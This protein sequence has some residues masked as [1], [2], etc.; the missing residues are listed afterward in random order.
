MI[1]P[2]PAAR[3]SFRDVL[4]RRVIRNVFGLKYW[5]GDGPV[6]DV[7]AIAL[8]LLLGLDIEIKG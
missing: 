4:G 8:Q 6:E 5:Q 7:P 1:P 2:Y 3:K